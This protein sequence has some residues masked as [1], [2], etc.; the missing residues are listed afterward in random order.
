MNPCVVN[1]RAAFKQVPFSSRLVSK[2]VLE[3]EEEE[4]EEKEQGSALSEHK[5]VSVR[6]LCPASHVDGLP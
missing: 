2:L 3:K 4:E 5:K 1:V 6:T